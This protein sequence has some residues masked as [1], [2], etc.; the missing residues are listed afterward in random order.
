MNQMQVCD[1]PGCKKL[2]CEYRGA[3]VWSRWRM[4]LR[5]F[6][7][8]HGWPVRDIVLCASHAYDEGFC[9]GCGQMWSGVEDFEFGNPSKLCSNCRDEPDF[10]LVIVA[11]DDD[12]EWELPA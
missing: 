3:P 10:G 2:G 9:W 4:A 1:K 5:R 12:H 7:A 8:R 6:M 11:E